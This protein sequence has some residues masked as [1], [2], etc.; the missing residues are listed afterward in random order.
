MDLP[1]A[2]STLYDTVSWNCDDYRTFTYFHV[3]TV[4]E[5]EDIGSD[6]EKEAAAARREELKAKMI[7]KSRDTKRCEFASV[8]WLLSIR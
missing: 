3:L 7:D 8:I 1:Y 4:L 6:A 5:Q 2:R